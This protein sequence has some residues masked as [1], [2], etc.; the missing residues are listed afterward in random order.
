MRFSRALFHPF[1][2]LA[3]FALA[4]MLSSFTLAAAPQ[5]FKAGSL[6]GIE[7]GRAGKPFI[8]LFWSLE[9]PSCLKEMDS[10]AAALAKYPDVDLVMV[11][12]DE[13]SYAQAAEAML[14][15]RH[16]QKA[17]AWIF[18]DADAQGLR[19]EIDPAWFGELPRAYFYDAAHQRRAHSGTLS[20]QEIE[21]WRKSLAA[22][23]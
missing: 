4:L 23:P 5:A 9:C 3:V 14:A 19:H 15:K 16:L 7:S 17:E 20:L 8:L 2:R 21:A 11:S 1:L 10:L 6:A 12:I 18:G 22:R 13:D